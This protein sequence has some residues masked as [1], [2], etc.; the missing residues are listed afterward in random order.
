MEAYIA[1]LRKADGGKELPSIETK[2]NFHESRFNLSPD[3]L[4]LIERNKP[5]PITRKAKMMQDK[6]E[7]NRNEAR[8][9]KK[10]KGGGTHRLQ[11]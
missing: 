8:R 7:A 10:A 1:E 4:D 9:R 2:V 5:D 3:Q 6:F 11:L